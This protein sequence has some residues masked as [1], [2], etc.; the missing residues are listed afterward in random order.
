MPESVEAIH[1]LIVFDQF[2]FCVDCDEPLSANRKRKLG[3]EGEQATRDAP[4]PLGTS[5]IPRVRLK[6]GHLDMILMPSQRQQTQDRIRSRGIDQLED[7]YG[8]DRVPP[9]EPP[10]WPQRWKSPAS[11]GRTSVVMMRP[12]SMC[13]IIPLT[14]PKPTIIVTE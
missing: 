13:S 14:V 5:D 4:E 8:L 12:V 9:V 7:L 11:T 2:R 3:R 6:E 10:A 1:A